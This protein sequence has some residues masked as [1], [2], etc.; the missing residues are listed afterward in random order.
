MAETTGKKFFASL[1][2]VLVFA[3][4]M[5]AT[6]I[7]IYFFKQIQELNFKVLSL[8]L[9]R[10][11]NKKKTDKVNADLKTLDEQRA[12]LET[13]L[14]S[15]NLESRKKI[16]KLSAEVQDYQSRTQN[17]QTKLAEAKAEAAELLKE[18][19]QLKKSSAAVSSKEAVEQP[20]PQSQKLQL[21]LA[22]KT[23]QLETLGARVEALEKELQ[24]KE[25]VIHYNLG[26]NFFKNQDFVNAVLEYKKAVQADPS[27]GPSYYNLG[28][29]HEE[30]KKDY[31][32]AIYYY[33]QYLLLA[34]QAEDANLVRQWIAELEAKTAGTK[35]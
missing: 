18:N 16:D 7:G 17:L 32:Q 14:E 15:L 23:E 4:G 11:E 3:Y 19:K 8:E 1:V 26:V 25:A 10:N 20:D 12:K 9:L 34:P 24:L 30:Y 6:G 13:M 21:A 31:P 33:Q 22:D 28:I 2:V 29:L 35:Y 5:A 27:H